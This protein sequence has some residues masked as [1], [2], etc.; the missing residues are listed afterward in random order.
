[1][2]AFRRSDPRE[3]CRVPPERCRARLLQ[4]PA[5]SAR[6]TTGVSIPTMVSPDSSG[7]NVSLP[8]PSP[9]AELAERAIPAS[10]R[11]APDAP[12]SAEQLAR[13]LA[14]PVRLARGLDRRRAAELPLRQLGHRDQRL[15][16][17]P[18]RV[19]PAAARD[20]PHEQ[21]G[22]AHV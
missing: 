18:A 7:V 19:G 5:R 6:T 2:E 17:P 11:I 15:A 10:R 4:Q 1:A 3:A 22:R 21:I 8:G 12:G 20:F 14:P 13:R 16:D 9:A